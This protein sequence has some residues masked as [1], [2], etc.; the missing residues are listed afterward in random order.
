M[1][2]YTKN[3]RSEPRERAK[4][5]FWQAV[6]FWPGSN[7]GPLYRALIAHYANRELDRERKNREGK[8]FAALVKA[9]DRRLNNLE[10]GRGGYTRMHSREAATLT[11]T[12]LIEAAERGRPEAHVEELAETVAAAYM[13]DGGKTAL[14]EALLAKECGIKILWL[15]LLVGIN[16]SV[17]ELSTLRH[18]HQRIGSDIISIYWDRNDH[19]DDAALS[20][21]QDVVLDHHVSYNGLDTTHPS[22]PAGKR[23]MDLP[24]H[25]R[26]AKTA[27]F[28]SAV[29]PRKYRTHHHQQWITEMAHAMAYAVAVS[30]TELDP[31]TVSC[32]LTGMYNIEAKDADSLVDR[33]RYKG[34]QKN[35][36]DM[37]FV[38]GYVMG[39]VGGDRGFIE[40]MKRRAHAKIARYTDTICT[41]VE[42]KF[43]I[44][45]APDFPK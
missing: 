36:Q 15:K 27:D 23:G 29:L 16:L 28:L 38:K 6:R 43:G 18:E 9:V 12:Q 34:E 3:A 42:K 10:N 1:L 40:V 35:L 5:P 33:L 22:Y 30:G 25:C 4:V 11:G 31:L 37:D 13:H 45:I 19:T 44:E 39:D 21:A 24:F 14:P 7:G 26:I 41:A 32:L 2:F 17:V 20:R 8:G